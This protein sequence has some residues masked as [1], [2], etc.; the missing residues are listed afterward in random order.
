MT[1]APMPALAAVGAALLIACTTSPNGPESLEGGS[2]LEAE[3][4]VHG[5]TLVLLNLPDTVWSCNDTVK[6]SQVELDEPDSFRFTVSGNALQVFQG[7]PDSIWG[8][9]NQLEG[10]VDNYSRFNRIG[11]GQG[12]EGRWLFKGYGYNLLSG[13]LS[14]SSKERLEFL[15]NLYLNR[16]RYV[17]EEYEFSDGRMILRIGGDFAGLYVA[18]WNGAILD[19]SLVSPDSAIYDVEVTRLG[20][21]S[22]RLKGRKTGETVTLTLSIEKSRPIWSYASDNPS[23]PTYPGSLSMRPCTAREWFMSDFLS[24]NRRRGVVISE[25]VAGGDPAAFQRMPNHPGTG[26]LPWP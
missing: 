15:Q 20:P 19:D 17:T 9:E 14:Q 8:L 12:L 3:Y 22:V 21:G 5:D 10:V 25:L 7:G 4:S 16:S 13:T 18:N 1:T 6:T 2:Y 26:V 24:N 11:G 23:H